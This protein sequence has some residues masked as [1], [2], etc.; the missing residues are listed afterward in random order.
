MDPAAPLPPAGRGHERHAATARL[1][2]RA[3]VA[4]LLFAGW[5]MAVT[6]YAWFGEP[7]WIEVTEHAVGT[8]APGARPL[9]IVQIADLHLRKIGARERRV[10][11]AVRGA[12]PDLLVLGGD[13]VDGPDGLPVLDAFVSLVGRLPS[14]VAVPGSWERAAGVDPESLRAVLAR[15]GVRLL[16][17][18]GLRLVHGGRSAWV[19][20]LDDLQSSRAD[21][22]AA[23]V[24]ADG[25]RN[26]VAVSHSPGARDAWEGPPP[27]FLLAA[28]THGGQVALLGFAPARPPGSAGYVA[29]WYRGA[30]FDVYVSRGVGT[31]FLPLRLGARPE[32]TVID[33]W[34][35]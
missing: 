22:R 34:L 10:A 32:V 15:R 12:H 20:G 11:E 1:L 23:T 16:V 7:G 35:E 3:I 14:A 26:L 13:L 19:A 25:I 21:P 17:N 29:G 2:H 6:L 9:R 8:P 28:Q 24:G 4:S 31:S 5:G 27:R 18:E 30:P 33:W